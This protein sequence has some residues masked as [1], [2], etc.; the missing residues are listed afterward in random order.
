[1]SKVL[2]SSTVTNI[3][4]EPGTGKLYT[5]DGSAPI[6]GV[7]GFSD[8]NTAIK[9]VIT[10]GGTAGRD[11]Q[12][13]RTLLNGPNE[14]ALGDGQEGD[15]Y[16]ETTTNSLYGPKTS[17]GW[18]TPVELKGDKGD[19]GAL[20]GTIDT[21]RVEYQ[22]NPITAIL[23]DLLYVIPDILTFTTSITET[24]VGSSVASTTLNWTLNKEALGQ[25][26]NGQTI[27][28]S[29]RTL[30]RTGPFTSNTTW[31]LGMEDERTTITQATSL[32]F[33]YKRYWG[34][35]TLASLN[36]AQIIALSSELATTRAKNITYNATGGQYIYYCYPAS[37]GNP[38][39]TV[40][41]LSFSDFTVTTRNF[42]NASGA[43]ASYNIIRF[44]TIQNGSSI[45]VNW[46]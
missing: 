6:T 30:V 2:S 41:G 45:E 19:D 14:P 10:T 17:L 40:G 36:D 31:T 44:N 46:S 15:F 37:F 18:G 5:P 1:M 33:K 23:D 42:V 29:L 13:G 8:P 39:V 12:D 21:D 16:L 32:T 22:G 35:S 28:P 25:T 43:T 4:V 11:G 3:Q 34:T 20:V 9:T 38:N 24:E 27:S 7:T 26:I